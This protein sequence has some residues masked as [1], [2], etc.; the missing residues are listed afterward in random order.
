M[1]TGVKY[2]EITD[3]G[4]TVT[5]REGNR[6]TIKADSMIPVV[7]LAPNDELCKSLQG[8]V[9]EIYSVGDC[10]KNGLIIDA[11]ADGYRVGREI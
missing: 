2:E 9:P 11:I 5:T 7:P 8:K 1:M 3:K 6:E 4:L 10:A